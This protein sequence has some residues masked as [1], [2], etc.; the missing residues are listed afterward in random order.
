MKLEKPFGINIHIKPIIESEVAVSE[1]PSI[2]FYG[3]VM[4]IGNKVQEVKVGDKL[5]FVSWGLNTVDVEGTTY[6]II[7]E[8]DKFILGY[9]N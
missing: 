9:I 3:E 2:C 6:Y 8:T 5:A 4:G 7:P 1:K